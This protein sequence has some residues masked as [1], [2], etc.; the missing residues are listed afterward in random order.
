MSECEILPQLLH[1]QPNASCDLPQNTSTSGIP[2]GA[3]EYDIDW[4]SQAWKKRIPLT[5]NA[6]QIPSKLTDYP[7][8]IDSTFPELVGVAEEEI[9]TSGIEN[10]ILPYQIQKFD[11]STGELI[12]WTKKPSIENS[13]TTFVYR[14]NSDAIDEQDSAAVWSDYMAVWLLNN[15]TNDSTANNHTITPTGVSLPN[16]GYSFNGVDQNLEVNVSGMTWFDTYSMRIDFE[17][18]TFGATGVL[19][20]RDLSISVFRCEMVH[21][22][23][24][25]R[26][27]WV[28][29]HDQ[30]PSDF[31]L[32][33][34][35]ALTVGKHTIVLEVTGSTERRWYLDG[36][37]IG[38]VVGSFF[39]ADFNPNR[40]A[41]ASD[42]GPSSGA[43]RERFL[44][45]NIF[46]I[47]EKE[48]LR[49]ADQILAEW[50][51]QTPSSFYSI[52]VEE[53]V[54]FTIPM[55]YDEPDI[56]EF[57]K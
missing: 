6:G 44:E 39:S 2:K 4:I 10:F 11:I 30:L 57:D 36:V 24:D 50:N 45:C 35:S 56:M 55:E 1:S 32:T 20:V 8:K 33:S 25:G 16:G 37:D 21:M 9:R 31:E 28:A 34:P 23:A 7:L 22:L 51:N 12:Y 41:F 48:S 5:I 54:P 46:G 49:G 18:T 17:I 19:F 29:D 42:F 26:I 52:G 40:Y 15:N 53:D 14:D 13:D 47:F 27:Q 3:M 38:N 43:P